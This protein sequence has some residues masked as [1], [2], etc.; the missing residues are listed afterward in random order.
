MEREE[1]LIIDLLCGSEKL[2]SSNRSEEMG[3]RQENKD[4]LGCGL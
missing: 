1:E 3:K 2:T 4:S